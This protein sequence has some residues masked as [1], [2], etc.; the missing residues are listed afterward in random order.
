MPWVGQI[1]AG[2]CGYSEGKITIFT[3]PHSAYPVIFN[4]VWKYDFSSNE[5]T[6]MA[7]NAGTNGSV[8]A[9]NGSNFFPGVYGTLGVPA[10]G[11]NPGS[12]TNQNTWTD[13]AGNFWLFGGGV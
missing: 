2:I 9:Y 12:R 4:D 7:G 1:A 13:K 3:G 11:N 6:W 5:W 10:A 8:V